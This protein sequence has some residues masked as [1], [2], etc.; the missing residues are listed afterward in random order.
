MT[1]LFIEITLL[2]ETAEL[3]W[4]RERLGSSLEPPVGIEPVVSTRRIASM[5]PK[6]AGGAAR[7]PG[8]QV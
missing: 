5:V 8:V 3:G 1:A 6:L 4:K 7:R 2:D